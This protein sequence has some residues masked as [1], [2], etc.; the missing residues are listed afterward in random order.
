MSKTCRDQRLVKKMLT[1]LRLIQFEEKL[2][3]LEGRVETW[4]VV[5][6]PTEDGPQTPLHV[7]YP[8]S[9]EA[10]ILFKLLQGT[11]IRD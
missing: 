10:H 11:K 5:K 4:G 1:C 7:L 6:S 2:T 8:Q 9:E 3:D